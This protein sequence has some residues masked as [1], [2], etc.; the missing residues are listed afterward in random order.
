MY[1]QVLFPQRDD[2]V[3]Q[4]F[5]LARESSFCDRRGEE[6]ALGLVAELVDQDSKAPR[7]IS[8]TNGRL[9]R[10]EPLNEEGSQGFVLAMSGVGRL[11]KPSS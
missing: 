4:S 8:E 11:E 10:G 6:S 7:G 1:G 5:L 9:S 3:P 2:L